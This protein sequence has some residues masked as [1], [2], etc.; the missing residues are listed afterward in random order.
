MSNHV[1]AFLVGWKCRKSEHLV[2]S[3]SAKKADMSWAVE[4]SG[5]EVY[6]EGRNRSNLQSIA[7][8]KSPPS[9][10]GWLRSKGFRR[11]DMNSLWAVGLP[12]GR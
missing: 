1:K 9:I 6:E 11:V 10:I 7:K 2:R 12:E 8:L 5:W 3:L 4:A